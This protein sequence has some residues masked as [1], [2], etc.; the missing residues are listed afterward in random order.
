MQF[1]YLYRYIFPS[2]YTFIVETKIDKET[3]V[4]N[5]NKKQRTIH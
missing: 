4:F 2:R 3:E 1:S 5:S